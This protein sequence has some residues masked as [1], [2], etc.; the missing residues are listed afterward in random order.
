MIEKVKGY[1][2]LHTVA[3]KV[4]GSILQP[5]ELEE[6]E[7]CLTASM[8]IAMYPT[9]GDNADRLLRIADMAMYQAKSN[10]GHYVIADPENMHLDLVQS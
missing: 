9:N 2:H 6:R 1:Q 5:F 7:Y 3:T 10:G 4:L 8:G